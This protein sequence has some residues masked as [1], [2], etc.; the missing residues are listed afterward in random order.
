VLAGAGLL[1]LL[2]RA[3]LWALAG[4]ALAGLAAAAAGLTVPG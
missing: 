1:L 2:G 4:G 3:A